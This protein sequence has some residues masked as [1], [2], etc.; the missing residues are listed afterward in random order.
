MHRGSS[1]PVGSRRR[2]GAGSGPESLRQRQ[3]TSLAAMERG[4]IRD[5]RHGDHRN[6]EEN[7]NSR[8]RRDRAS[9]DL[10][11]D[12]SPR[13]LSTRAERAGS[14]RAVDNR[15]TPNRTSTPLLAADAH[16]LCKPRH[17]KDRDVSRRGVL[18]EISDVR[19]DVREIDQIPREAVRP[20]RYAP[21]FAAT[22]PNERPIVKRL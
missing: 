20:T 19:N 13:H 16:G 7:A 9:A 1:D 6:D 15:R 10:W 8:V 22:R 5:E 2:A 4:A 11:L 18:A 21:R 3:A 12:V 17:R 14:E